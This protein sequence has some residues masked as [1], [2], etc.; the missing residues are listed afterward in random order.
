VLPATA[1]PMAAIGLLGLASLAGYV[2]LRL[3]RRAS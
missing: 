1:S 3:R 2:T